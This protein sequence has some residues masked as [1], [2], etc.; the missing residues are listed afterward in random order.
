MK[1]IIAGGGTAGHI[2]PALAIADL[3]VEKL[4][5]SKGDITF[6]GTKRGL[7][8][9]L[10]P[11]ADYD[12]RYITVRGFKRKFSLNTIV[13]LFALCVGMV[14]SRKILKELSP[15][16]VI[17][18]GGYVAGPIMYL[19]S[20]RKI[21]T[22]LHEANAYP[23]IT[24]RLLA[25]RMDVIGISFLKSKQFLKNSKKII[26]TG[27][28][29]RNDILNLNRLECREKI[30]LKVNEKLVVVMGGSLGARAINDSMIQLINKHLKDNDFTLIYAPGK[31]YYS[32][33]I[34]RINKD[35]DNVSI[36]DYIY[37]SPEVY[38]S[39]DLMITRGGSMTISEMLA[40][41][42]PS[43]IIPSSNVA[44]NHQEP[45]ARAVESKGAC[46]VILDKQLNGLVLYEKIV[47]I[48]QNEEKMISM[49]ES[50]LKMGIIDGKERILDIIRK[51]V[52]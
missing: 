20:R 5:L 33:V 25:K 34:D 6:I 40:I 46:E 39:A 38:H 32:E 21:P 28:P 26:L 41:G 12:L 45:N 11:R 29:L 8:K 13:G 16:I 4:N 43:I 15:D 17:G 19:A 48:L 24:T 36:V 49:R 9:D 44:E 37:N 52:K 51:L 31:Q 1:V 22:F 23:G 47:N 14:Q 27:N 35:F 10:V 30:S 50:A 3:L 42:V 7:E 18:T 2:N